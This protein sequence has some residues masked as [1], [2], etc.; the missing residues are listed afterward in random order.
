[1]FTIVEI[2]VMSIFTIIGTVV[3]MQ[4]SFINWVKKKRIDYD[5]ELR[6]IRLRRKKQQAPKNK[7][8]GVLDYVDK[9]KGLNPD[10]V[11]AVLDYVGGGTEEPSGIEDSILGFAKENPEIVKSFLEGLGSGHKK[12]TESDI[13]K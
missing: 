2:I 1:M 3:I 5:Y 10:M 9:L 6:K 13:F 11:N 8:L 12:T 4:F 7:P